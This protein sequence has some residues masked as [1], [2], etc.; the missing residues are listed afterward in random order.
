MDIGTFTVQVNT[1]KLKVKYERNFHT[2]LF[3]VSWTLISYATSLCDYSICADTDT[4]LQILVTPL[5]T[6]MDVCSEC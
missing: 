1:N 2:Y 5:S 3:A 6:H 4:E